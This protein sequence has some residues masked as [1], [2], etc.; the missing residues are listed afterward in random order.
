MHCLPVLGGFQ[1]WS[2]ALQ[3]FWEIMKLARVGAGREKKDTH[4]GGFGAGAVSS[5]ESSRLKEGA[6]KQAG[7]EEEGKAARGKSRGPTKKQKHMLEGGK[8]QPSIE[9]LPHVTFC[10]LHAE[11]LTL[12]HLPST[13][14]FE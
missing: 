4:S 12:G 7:K 3:D 11:N 13:P 14:Q 8:V 5:V 2:R 9:L 1:G 10:H 6:R